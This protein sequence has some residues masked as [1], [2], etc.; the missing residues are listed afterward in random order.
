[1]QAGHREWRANTNYAMGDCSVFAVNILFAL[2][3]AFIL[4][5]IPAA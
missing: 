5:M 4:T 2:V 3:M 1:L